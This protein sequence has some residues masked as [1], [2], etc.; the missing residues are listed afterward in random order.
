MSGAE[1]LK[2]SVYLGERDRA[3]RALL[4]E[5]L[6][7]LCASGGVRAAALLRGVEGFGLAHRLQT[8]RLLTLS[9]D[10]PVLLVAIDAPAPVQA[11]LDR[12][13]EVSRHGVITLERVWLLEGADAQ[14]PHTHAEEQLKLT[15]LT[16]GAERAS[17]RPAHVAAVQE[18]HARGLA[19]AS[20]LRGVDGVAG[21]A[22][23]RARMLS[24]NTEVPSVIDALGER[25]QLA[26]AVPALGALLRQPLVAVER[27]RV[28]K[29]EGRLLADPAEHP[30]RDSGGLHYWQKLV[31]H[32]D[33]H[34]RHAGA[35]LHSELVRRLR[36]AG[37]AG[38]TTLR[39]QWGY[40]G[41]RTPH[42]EPLLALRRQAPL[43]T[44]L[45]D[46][47]Q[48][49]L[50]WFAIVDELTSETGLVTSEIV[51]ALR[52][53]ASG[54]EHGGLRLAAERPRGQR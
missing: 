8:D 3:G 39:A 54:V 21:G 38:A 11:L 37:A 50:R 36:R 27:A 23:R 9:E 26:G 14:L 13:R 47:P 49:M 2:L 28:C 18:L 52:A 17:G 40:A 42:G 53:A 33:E 44:V 16:R 45:L 22:R 43:M 4:A 10:L 32:S 35:P 51:P 48:N 46:T 1:G 30:R 19:G 24:R 31:V 15:L 41:E 5:R 12:V 25:E 7:E 34:D 20:V 6:L 29:R